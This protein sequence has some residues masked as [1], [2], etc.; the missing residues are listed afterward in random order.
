MR[1]RHVSGVPYSADVFFPDHRADGSTRPGRPWFWT[2]LEQF[3]LAKSIALRM[4]SPKDAQK[5]FSAAAMDFH[6]IV[7]NEIESKK[8]EWDR[9]TRRKSGALVGTPR[10]IVDTGELR[11]SQD[12]SV[13]VLKSINS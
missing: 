1:S 10:D 11:N 2:A 13:S 8:W 5:A 12:F 7:L 4:R 6:E 3:D 9:L